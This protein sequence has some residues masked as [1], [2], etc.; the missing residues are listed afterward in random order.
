MQILFQ[1]KEKIDFQ[2][3]GM[4]RF[5][6]LETFLQA[7]LRQGFENFGIF[8][9]RYVEGGDEKFLWQKVCVAQFLLFF[10]SRK[11]DQRKIVRKICRVSEKCAVFSLCVVFT[12]GGFQLEFVFVQARM[13]GRA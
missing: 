11:T 13:Q 3:A 2:S 7:E 6:P 10:C 9:W 5:L 1:N 8:S 4:R 12:N